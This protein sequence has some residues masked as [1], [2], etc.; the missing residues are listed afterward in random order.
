MKGKE[1]RNRCDGCSSSHTLGASCDF[2][3]VRSTAASDLTGL[4]CTFPTGAGTLSADARQ[5][6]ELS[7]FK[8]GFRISQQ[9]YSKLI[10]VASTRKV[11]LIRPNQAIN[12]VP[13]IATVLSRSAVFCLPMRT[14]TASQAAHLSVQGLTAAGNDCSACG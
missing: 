1:D 11:Q 2:C 9:T 7:N 6:C 12:K 10:R 4:L 8:P 14:G 13:Q 3:E 5:T